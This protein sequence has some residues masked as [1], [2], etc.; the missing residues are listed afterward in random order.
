[1]SRSGLGGFPPG[2]AQ[3]SP[4]EGIREPEARPRGRRS[5]IGEAPRRIDAHLRRS[6]PAGL[7]AAPARMALPAACAAL[8]GQPGAPRH[9]A[10]RQDG[11]VGGDQRRLSGRGD[12][13]P[14]RG[15]RGSAGAHGAQP[16]RGGRTGRLM[17]RAIGGA[18][19]SSRQ[20]CLWTGATACC[21]LARFCMLSL[22]VRAHGDSPTR[23]DGMARINRRLAVQR[24]FGTEGAVHGTDR[25]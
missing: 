17:P 1:M 19:G 10:H 22:A 2:L 9:A 11:R 13:S 18:L 5:P 16:G 4:R 24:P 6:D 15:R 8:A 21:A 20:G 25:H 23:C 3:G 7:E 14:T 12:G